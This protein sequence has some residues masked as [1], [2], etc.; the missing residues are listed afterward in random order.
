MLQAKW[1]YHADVYIVYSKS[2]DTL[3]GLLLSVSSNNLQKRFMNIKFYAVDRCRMLLHKAI[4]AEQTKTE[5]FWDVKTCSLVSRYLL[6]LQRCRWRFKSSGIWR[7]LD[8]SVGLARTYAVPTPFIF[9]YQTPSA[10][11]FAV[12]VIISKPTGLLLL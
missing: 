4:S 11:S 5:L 1:I 9:L 7:R 8:W 2:S 12:C 3:F 10:K 6:L